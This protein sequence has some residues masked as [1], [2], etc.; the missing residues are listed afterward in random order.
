MPV[1]EYR[2]TLLERKVE[3]IEIRFERASKI[4]EMQA[5]LEERLK[6]LSS[7]L[8]NAEVNYRRELQAVE[9]R[10]TARINDLEA[11]VKSLNKTLI[12]AGVSV[13]LAAI[14]F[15]IVALQVFGG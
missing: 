4:A 1:E 10:L 3:A 5:V 9:Q 8:Q 2:V 11:D 13:T 12:G 7:E 6:T 15:A 14:G